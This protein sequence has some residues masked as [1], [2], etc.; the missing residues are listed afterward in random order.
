M[1]CARDQLLAGA[2]FPGDQDGRVRKG[3]LLDGIE[4]ALEFWGMRQDILEP[5]GLPQLRSQTNVF[6]FCLLAQLANLLVGQ[7]IRRGDRKRPGYILQNGQLPWRKGA[8]LD[9]D[10]RGHTDDLS[11]H[12]QRY[13]NI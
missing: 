12:D 7:G 5:G 2:G 1:N 10:E 11:P 4:Y 9:S 13:R 3:D 8:L 6:R